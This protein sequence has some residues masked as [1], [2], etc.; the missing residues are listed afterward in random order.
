MVTTA[1]VLDACLISA[2]VL[3]GPTGTGLA[4]P[5]FVFYYPILLAFAFVL[6][7]S[8]TALYTLGVAC[9]YAVICFADV[10]SLTTA[11][12]LV[13]RL[14]TMAA[15]GGLGM[16]YWRIQRDGRLL[17]GG[18]DPLAGDEAGWRRLWAF[19]A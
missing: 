2:I 8:L 1:S 10:S 17:E 14:A 11:K 18:T 6:P 19:L 4:S 3:L 13:L 7:R 9:T 16:F 15:M 12:V 5:F